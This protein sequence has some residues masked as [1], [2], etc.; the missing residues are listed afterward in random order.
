MSIPVAASLYDWLLLLHI[1]AAMVW[2]GGLVAL[3]VISALVLR[4]GDPD[5]VARFVAGLRTVGPVMLAPAS[6]GVVAFGIWLVV[7][8]D[9]WDFGQAWIVTA[10]TL[11][12]AA[13]LVGAAFLSRAALSAQ[14]AV[15]AGDHSGAVVHLR[16]WTW[17][18]RVLGLVL[19]I[20]TWDMVMKPGL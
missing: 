10:L 14:A 15:E 7:E 8:S 11:V 9:A 13:V 3:T 17:G 20:A 19:V 5:A 16:R 2:L 12:V 1:L 6:L 18:V 4:S